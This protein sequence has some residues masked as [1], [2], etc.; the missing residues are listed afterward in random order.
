MRWLKFNTVGAMGGTIHLGLL[1]LFIH[2]VGMNYLL[3]TALSVEIAI[4]H[5]FIWHWR[6]TWADRRSAQSDAPAALF[7]FNL[8]NGLVS[9]SG[10]VLSTYILTGIWRIDP[11]VANLVSIALGSLA[12]L[13]LSDRVVFAQPGSLEQPS[14]PPR[15]DPDPPTAHN[16][17]HST[18]NRRESETSPTRFQEEEHDRQILVSDI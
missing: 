15:D 8:T 9:I 18:E 11:V 5:N 1:A 2:L 3:A 4:L 6:W 10:N 12:N 13:F 17:N 14:E 16:V 7:R